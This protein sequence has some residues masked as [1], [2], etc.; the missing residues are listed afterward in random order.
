MTVTLT[1]LKKVRSLKR[2]HPKLKTYLKPPLDPW[3]AAAV[4]I[5]HEGDDYPGLNR[6][7][8]LQTELLIFGPGPVADAAVW[9]VNL[10]AADLMKSFLLG[11]PLVIQ[12]ICR[13]CH[14]GRAVPN[15]PRFDLSRADLPQPIVPCYI[16]TWF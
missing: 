1:H 11:Y 6:R 9:C 3:V 16:E 8:L 7:H 10:P 4:Y 12:D 5:M 14:P 2:L 13:L 15:R